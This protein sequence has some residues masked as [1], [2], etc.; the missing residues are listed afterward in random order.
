MIGI[1]RDGETGAQTPAGASPSYTTNSR[2]G[3]RIRVLN[4]V[5]DVRRRGG[6]GNH[7]SARTRRRDP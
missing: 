5:D 3:A 1:L 2:T 7:V 6:G 4:I